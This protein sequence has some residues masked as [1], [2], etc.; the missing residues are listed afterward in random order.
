MKKI[1]RTQKLM[2]AIEVLSDEHMADCSDGAFIS[3]LINRNIKVEHIYRALKLMRYEWIPSK[4][5]WVWKPRHDKNIEWMF[6]VVSKYDEEITKR[7][8]EDD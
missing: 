3:A 2:K 6:K 1:I 8:L 4:G 7:M 5:Y